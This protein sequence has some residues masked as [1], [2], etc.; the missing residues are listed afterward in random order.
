MC[1]AEFP[2]QETLLEHI[3]LLHGQY[4]W[5]STCLGGHYSL[6]AYY[7]SPTEKRACVEH[8]AASQQEA[9]GDHENEAY[10]PLMDQETQRKQF[11][12]YVYGSCANEADTIE[13]QEH[14]TKLIDAKD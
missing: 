12:A 3:N 13:S 14:A 7:A 9:T 8:F 6:S 2:N 4:R 10:A 11:W 1:E 5:Y